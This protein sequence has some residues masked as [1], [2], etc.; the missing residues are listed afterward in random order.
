MFSANT[1]APVKLVLEVIP[2]SAMR[3]AERDAILT[4]SK[5][6]FLVKLSLV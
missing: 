1:F 4:I 3:Y 2:P 6:I 5:V